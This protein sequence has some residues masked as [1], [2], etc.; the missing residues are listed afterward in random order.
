M[1]KL[2]CLV[3]WFS[4]V[5]ASSVDS[6]IDQALNQVAET[7]EELLQEREELLRTLPE[8]YE[9]RL[10]VIEEALD[11]ADSIE[12]KLTEYKQRLETGQGRVNY[13]PEDGDITRV[14][15]EVLGIS[16]EK[17]DADIEYSGREGAVLAFSGP[18]GK[19]FVFGTYE[20]RFFEEDEGRKFT[21]KWG[22]VIPYEVYVLLE[23]GEESC[24]YSS[25]VKR[26]KIG[27]CPEV[28]SLKKVR[29]SDTDGEKLYMVGEVDG[30][31]KGK[32]ITIEVPIVVTPQ[33]D[34]VGVQ[35]GYGQFPLYLSPQIEIGSLSA[36]VP[37]FDVREYLGGELLIGR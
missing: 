18:N 10:R 17:L 23:E 1:G 32:I 26:K 33:G 11:K 12:R 13:I 34:S 14:L 22:V 21:P 19:V 8:G 2:L 28:I 24:Y 36:K 27:A 3:L 16:Q 5:L 35:S 7:K 20:E 6:T 15:K 31:S 4:I 30:V 25:N 9:E 29:L 37:T